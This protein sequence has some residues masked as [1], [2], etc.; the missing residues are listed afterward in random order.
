MKT[1]IVKLNIQ[2]GEY[3]KSTQKLIKALSVEEAERKALLDECHGT[4]GENS[5]W[6]HGGIANLA[7]EFHYSVSSCIEVSPEHVR[8]LE[9][10]C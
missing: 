10:Y 5:E 6:A 2:A 9:L 1:F 7:W 4:I 8:T 3:A